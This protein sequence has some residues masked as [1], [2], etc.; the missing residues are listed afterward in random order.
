MGEKSLLLTAEQLFETM[1]RPPGEAHIHRFIGRY[2]RGYKLRRRSGDA[3][4][5]MT[6]LHPNKQSLWQAMK[7]LEGMLHKI[8]VGAGKDLGLKN[9]FIEDHNLSGFNPT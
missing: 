4:E 7:E 1:G 3:V 8:S 9:P 6:G 5:D 2:Q